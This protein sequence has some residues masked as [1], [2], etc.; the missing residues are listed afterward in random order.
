MWYCERVMS[1]RNA[2][3]LD[4]KASDADNERIG[5]LH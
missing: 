1:G 3:S 2:A 5:D 4:M